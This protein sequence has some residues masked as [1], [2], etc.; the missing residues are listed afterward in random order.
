MALPDILRKMDLFHPL[1][2]G[3]TA[4]IREEIIGRAGLTP[5]DLLHVTGEFDPWDV[6]SAQKAASLTAQL[7]GTG[8]DDLIATVKTHISERI[9]A[10]IISFI[11]GKTL[12]RAPYYT[13]PDDLGLW[14][15]EENL[16]RDH[17]FLGSMIKL[18]VPLIGIGAPAEILLPPVA[19]ALHT[20]LVTPPHYQVA[21]AIGAVAGSVISNQEAWVLG[22]TRNMRPVG[23]L[24]QTG[25]TRKHFPRLK[26]ALNYARE[27]TGEKA[28]QQAQKIGVVDPH[29]E[30]EQLPDGA[31]T[32][33]IRARAI[34]NP[35]LSA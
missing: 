16:Y 7:Y 33:R 19:E 14:L 20:D 24:V 32:Y 30:Y 2:F 5:T 17:P 18:K 27:I 35:R 13:D 6:S 21:N 31:D 34:G 29:L 1:Q 10:E 12:E 23:Y 4:L 11:T 3:G 26:E 9:S 22:Q 15:F 8:L 28:L 25:S